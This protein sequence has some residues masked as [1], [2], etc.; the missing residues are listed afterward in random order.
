MEKQLTIEDIMI[1][2]LQS[3]KEI[4]LKLAQQDEAVK[5]LASKIET[6]FTDYFTIAGYASIR[7]LKVD[8]SQVNRL[9]Q[10]AMRLSQDY[11]IMT[12]KVND[13]DLGDFNTYHLDIL[14]EVFDDR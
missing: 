1:I 6:S 2:S 10:M 4:K 5:T 7:G 12:S 13:L 11:R 14:D 8:I 3:L 9:E